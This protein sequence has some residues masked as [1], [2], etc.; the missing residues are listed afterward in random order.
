MR[1]SK[2]L[3]QLIVDLVDGLVDLDHRQ[4]LRLLPPESPKALLQVLRR[5]SM[6]I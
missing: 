1:S 4:L 2:E 6:P 5:T 3:P